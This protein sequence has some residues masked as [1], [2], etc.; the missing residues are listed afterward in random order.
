LQA[1]NQSRKIIYQGHEDV[2]RLAVWWKERT[3]D[4]EFYACQHPNVLNIITGRDGVLYENPGQPGGLERALRARHARFLL[5]DLNSGADRAADREA[6]SGGQ[7]RLVREQGTAR[8]YEL[9]G[10]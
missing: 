8:L 1:H 9:S 5:L 2:E 7:L 10:Q 3:G 4:G 6:A